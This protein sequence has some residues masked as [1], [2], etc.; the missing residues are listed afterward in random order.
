MRLTQA[1]FRDLYRPLPRWRAP[2]DDAIARVRDRDGTLVAIHLRR[3]DFGKGRFFVAPTDW[4][5]QWLA[6]NWAGWNRPVLYI[7]SDAPDKVVCNF[8]EYHPVTATDLGVEMPGYPD[9]PD[10][11]LLTQADALATSNSSYSFSASMLNER[12]HMF[13]RPV[14][15][16]RQLVPYD[17]WNSP[18]LLGIPGDTYYEELYQ[19]LIRALVERQDVAGL[20]RVR[21]ALADEWLTTPDDSLP[22]VFH[23]PLGRAQEMAIQ[24]GIFRMEPEGQDQSY[25]LLAL[26]NLRSGLGSVWAIQYLLSAMLFCPAHELPMRH[27]LKLIPQWLLPLYIKYLRGS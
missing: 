24:K 12:A 5:R 27:D 23:A 2:L 13:V 15:S 22:V 4:Y 18:V 25:I 14:Y 11:Y 20:H 6:E 16:R 10:Y 21:R 7:A 19:S 1:A 9:Y 3:G 8:A 26:S 17:P